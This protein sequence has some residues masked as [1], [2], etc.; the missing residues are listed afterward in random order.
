LIKNII[1]STKHEVIFS[2]FQSYQENLER[3]K[4]IKSLENK[5]LALDS[6]VI[7]N[8]NTGFILTQIILKLLDFIVFIIY[9]YKGLN[10]KNILC[11][12]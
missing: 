11:Q 8:L 10:Y 7:P 3:I 5:N 1:W 9:P 4:K 6:F 2:D 12:V